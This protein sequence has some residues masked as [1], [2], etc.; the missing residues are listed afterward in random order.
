M[1]F[2]RIACS[3]YSFGCSSVD[4]QAELC[5]SKYRL[6]CEAAFR[7]PAR[8]RINEDG[9]RGK[10][11]SDLGYEPIAR[12][13]ATDTQRRIAARGPFG[14]FTKRREDYNQTGYKQ[15]SSQHFAASGEGIRMLSRT[16]RGVLGEQKGGRHHG[17]CEMTRGSVLC[18]K[19]FQIDRLGRRRH[20]LA[21][22]T[23]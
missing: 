12:R 8:A 23:S 22:L 11:L 21:A 1:T 10:E 9:Q 20:P 17:A 13:S 18:C 6:R 4:R 2:D 3:N 16:E 15:P 19:D 14:K 5:S 7:T